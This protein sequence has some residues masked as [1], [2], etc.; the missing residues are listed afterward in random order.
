MNE[1]PSPARA[2]F[3]RL[4]IV[5]AAAVGLVI[6]AYGWSVTQINLERPQEPVRQQNVGN[7]LRELLSPNVLEQQYEIQATTISFLIE[8][9]ADFQ[10][11]AAPP[12]AEGQPSIVVSPA[13]GSANEKITVQGVN[14]YPDS[15]ARMTWITPD[16]ERRIRQVDESGHDNFV[17]N[18]DGTFSVEIEVPRIRGTAGQTH[19]IEAQGR[20]PIGAPRFTATTHLVMEKMIETIFLALIATTLSILPSAVLSFFA[21]HNLMRSVRMSL[22]NLL[23]SVV[24]LPIGWWLGTMI[25]GQI[26]TLALNLSKGAGFTFT[27]SASAVIFFAAVTSS[28]KLPS[29][30]I[31]LNGARWRAIVNS[32]LFA[33]IFIAVTGLIGGLSILFGNNVKDG[34]LGYVGNFVGSLG[35]LTELVMPLLAG[36]IGAFSLSSIGSSLTMDALKRV[37]VP[38]SHLLGGVLGAISGAILLAFTAMI[39]MGAAWLGLLTPLVAALL[40][41]QILP[42]LYR[43]WAGKM[44]VVTGSD[45]VVV[46]LLGWGSTAIIFVIVFTLLNTGRALVEGTLPR[47]DV[48]FEVLG[49]AVTGFVWQSMLIGGL[50]GGIA[51]ALAGTKAAFP[52]GDILY[53]V[54]RTILNGLRSIEP[55]IM[56]LVFVIW[57]GIGPFAG[58]LALT[59]HS[60]ASLGK[61]YSEQIE[62]IDTGPIEAL[63]STGANRLQTIMYAVVPQIIPPYIAFTMYR[64][65]INVRMSTIIGFVGGGGVGFL[66]QQQINLLRYRDAGVAVLAIAIVVSVLDYASASIRERFV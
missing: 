23:V 13:C 62:S 66:L 26:G 57:V 40:G 65:D 49:Y 7:A 25:L 35:R 36:V 54:T 50:L 42:M 44:K 37:S 64:W 56:G 30:E 39:G 41:G 22:G 33:V 8:C 4:V 34:I 11:P 17:T 59:L 60:I 14:F 47:Q 38:V 48:V 55:L 29:V 24:L 2:A 27:A 63:Q 45:R 6:F 53:N 15:L 32:L 58:V 61:L 3:R 9:P 18:T 46:A 1:T 5:I 51:G 10:P 20:F 31:G 43:R 12:A 21:A 19:I 52:I 28:R 16:G